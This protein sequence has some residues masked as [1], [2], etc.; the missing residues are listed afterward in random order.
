MDQ[1]QNFNFDAS[2]AIS[3]RQNR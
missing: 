3:S 2:L 1:Y